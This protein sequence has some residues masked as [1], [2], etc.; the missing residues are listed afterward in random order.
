MG[1]VR[2]S[3]GL[4]Y[5]IVYSKQRDVMILICLGYMPCCIEVMTAV[6]NS[7]IYMIFGRGIRGKLGHVA[8]IHFPWFDPSLH[9]S[10]K[11]NQFLK[12]FLSWGRGRVRGGLLFFSKKT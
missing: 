9:S 3:P 6:G 12:I 2:A 1:T 8:L 10:V 4:T 7:D 11:L 5:G